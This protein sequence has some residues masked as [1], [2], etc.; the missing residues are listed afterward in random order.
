MLK[1]EVF[2]NKIL[3]LDTIFKAQN[4]I[5]SLVEL[6]DI[7][8][9]VTSKLD[10]IDSENGELLKRIQMTYPN[11]YNEVEFGDVE[12]IIELYSHVLYSM[13]YLV[14]LNNNNY[15][16][17]NVLLNEIAHFTPIIVNDLMKEFIPYSYPTV[18]EEL[19]QM[20]MEVSM[21]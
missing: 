2:F 9:E 17:T 3:E 6:D 4:D 19:E 1:F 13:R 18:D 10:V 12:N 11:L 20:M 5:R 14:E 8:I 7:S 21:I 15:Y 16:D